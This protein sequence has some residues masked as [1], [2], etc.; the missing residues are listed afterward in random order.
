M[1]SVRA[2]A[3]QFNGSWGRKRCQCAEALL[4]FFAVTCL[5]FSWCPLS[6][7]D[8]ARLAPAQNDAPTR[9]CISHLPSLQLSI[10]ACSWEGEGE[11]LVERSSSSLPRPLRLFSFI[12][13]WMSICSI[14]D[15]SRGKRLCPCGEVGTLTYTEK[16]IITLWQRVSIIRMSLFVASVSPRSH[17][18]NYVIVPGSRELWWPTEEDSHSKWCLSVRFDVRSGCRSWSMFHCV[19]LTDT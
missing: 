9:V 15:E 10:I 19:T 1:V 8:R 4:S 12:G 11:L 5:L 2:Q 18:A 16:S 7:I 17:A 13:H 14:G 3:D 6:R